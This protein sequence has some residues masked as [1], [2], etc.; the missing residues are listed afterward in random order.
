[1][2]ERLTFRP[3]RK[4][5][6]VDRERLIGLL[7]EGVSVSKVAK[8]LNRTEA[9]IRVQAFKARVSASGNLDQ[10]KIR[11]DKLRRNDR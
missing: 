1:M 10:R 7:G 6:H 2:A 4:W 5:T 8:L 3:N 9:A 11:N